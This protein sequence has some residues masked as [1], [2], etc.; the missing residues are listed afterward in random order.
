[1]QNQDRNKELRSQEGNQGE[2]QTQNRGQGQVSQEGSQSE[3]QTPQLPA[4]TLPKGGGAIRGI[5]E[6]FTANPV[7][8]TG[9][10]AVPI[11]VTPSRSG[12]G[13]ELALSYNSGSGNSPFGFGWDLSLPSIT[14]KTDKGLPRYFDGEESDVFI[15]SGA[16]DLVPV[17]TEQ[18]GEWQE[19]E[20]EPQEIDSV[21]YTIKR[22]RP[23][24]EGLFARIER[25]TNQDT[26]ESHWRSITN[27][28]ITTLYGKTTESRIVNPDDPLQIF[29]WLICESYDD[30][31]NAI[32]Y[33]YKPEDRANVGNS[34][35]EERNKQG[36]TSQRYLKRIKYGNSTPRQEGE[37]LS[38]RDDW[39]FEAVFDYGE[40]DDLVPTTAEVDGQ[41]WSVRQ[42]SF[43]NHRAG[44][45][46]RT[47]RLCKRVLMFHHFPDEL[48]VSDYLV[49]STNFN[50]Q[51][52]P[53]ASFIS[54]VEQAGYVRQDDGTYLRKAMPPLELEYSKAI[55]DE[56]VHTLDDKSL[57]N[58]PQG[59]DGANYRWVD[60]DGEGM[61]G[62]L[63]EQG[64]AWHYK[65]NLG[66]GKFGSVT[67]VAKI[68]STANLTQ[69]QQL[70]DLAGDAKLDLAGFAGPTPGFYERT[71]DKSWDSF[72]AFEK[73]PNVNWDDPNLRFVDLT[74]DGLADILIT[75]EDIHTFYPSLGEEGF[76][77][78]QQVYTP[79]N[80]EAGP[81][82]IFAD[83]MQS[84]YLADMS[85][86]GLSDLVK[87]S[88]G[89][90][91]YW[92]SL[93]Y[94]KFGAK[95]TMDN[96]PLFD[97]PDLFEQRRIQLADIDGSGVA[98]IVYFSS[99]GVKLYFNESG[100]SW[101]D[102][103]VLN[104]PK[105]DNLS[106]VAVMDLLGKGTACLVWSSPLPNNQRKPMQYIDLM[107]EQKPYLLLAS[108]NNMG[109]ETRVKYVP[110]TK[111]YR[112]DELKGEPWVTRLPFP[113]HVVERVETHDNISQNRFVS[114]Y[115]YHHGFFDGVEREFRGFG[116]VEQWDTEEYAALTDSEDVPATN[117]DEASHIPPVKTKTW[118]HMGAYIEGHKISQHFVG[119]YYGV[120]DVSDPDYE[121]KF[122]SF[123]GT[124]LPDSILPNTLHSGD[125]TIPWKLTAEEEREASRALK[126]SVLRQEIYA[127]DGTAKAEHPYSVS[128][129]NYTIELLQPEVDN[130]Y[131][132]FFA[133]PRESISYQY[134]RNPD[135]PRISHQ[136]VLEVDR[137]GNALKSAAVGYGRDEAKSRDSFLELSEDNRSI[138]EGKQTTTLLTYS[139]SGFTN[140]IEEA[141]VYQAPLPAEARTYELTGL[142]PAG[143]RFTFAEVLRDISEVSEIPYEAT[144]DGTKQKRLIEHV[145]TLYRKNDLSGALPFGEV[146]SLA[147]PYESY[148]LALTPELINQVYENRVTETM[149]N[150]GGYIH[151][152]GDANWWIPSG[153]IFYSPNPNDSP[154]EELD[155]AQQHFFLPHRL[156]DPF[157]NE[158]T[159]EY[160]SYNL[161]PLKSVD[162]LDNTIETVN[163]YR[164]LQPRLVTDPNG[165]RSEAAFDVLGMVVGTA[166]MGK[167]GENVGDSLVGFETDL[168]DDV[169]S[170][171]LQDPFNDP[172][173]I[174][175][176]ATSRL[177]YDLFAYQRTKD[178]ASPK[179]N[180]VYAL[181]RETHAADL[182]ANEL[183]K[184]QHSF[185]YSDGFGR[186]LQQ[187]I[188]AEPGL[189]D[190]VPTDPRWVGSGWTIYNNKGNPV[191]QYQ[192][193]FSA[194]HEFELETQGVS[195]T[196][197]YDPLERVVATLHPNHTFEKVVFDPWQQTTYDVNDTVL[198]NPKDDVD[199]GDYFKRL[200]DDTYLPTWY[201]ARKDGQLG[202][203]EQ[204][205]AERAALHSETPV[206]AYSD[207]LGRAFLTV[208]HNKFKK[209]VG[210]VEE[211]IEEKHETRVELDIESNQRVVI[212]ARGLEVMQYDYGMLGN[213]I[214]QV[215]MDAGTRW[216]F[217]DVAGKP[218]Y[219]WDS[220]DHVFRSTYD[221]LQRPTGLYVQK[222]AAEEI[223]FER[224]VYGEA[225]PDSQASANGPPLSKLNLRG[226]AFMQLDSAGASTSIGINAATGEEEAFDFKGNPLRGSRQLAKE[227][228]EQVDWS[229]LES[230]FAASELDLAA[231]TSNL[232]AFLEAETFEDSTTFDA[233]SR[234]IIATAPDSSVIRPTFNE[235]NLL[236][237]VE[238]NLRGA[239]EVT[240]FVSNID[241]DAKGQRTLIEY[242]NGARTQYT[243]DPDTF[244]L[245]QLFT[246]RGADFPTDCPDPA[247]RPCGIQNLHYTYDPVGNIT[248]IRDDAQ[249]TVFF[250]NGVAA[251]H[252]KYVYDALYR[253]IGAEGRE[254]I[255][256]VTNPQPNHDDAPRK[257]NPLPSDGQAMRRYVEQYEYDEVGNILK[258]IHSL[259]NLANPGETVWNRRYQYRLDNNQLVSTSQPS[260]ADKPSYSNTPDYTD[261]YT[262]DAHGNM[263]MPHLPVM[264]WDFK[265]QLAATSKQVRNSGGTPETTYYV[266][267]ASGQRV[268]K[269]TERQAPAGENPRRMKERI[270]LGDFEV[271]KEYGGDGETV[272][273]ERETLHVMDD[274]Q[275]IALV[276]TRTQGINPA[277]QQLIRYQFG[278]HLGSAS[279][280]LDDQAQVISYEE[281]T[282]Y[283]STAYQAVRSQTETPKRYR[284]TGMERDEESGLSYHS[285]RYYLPWLGLW[286]TIDPIG[287]EDS[288][289]LYQYT[290]SNPV[291]FFDS[292]G[293]ETKGKKKSPEQLA[294]D[295]FEEYL[296]KRRIKYKK[297]V[298]IEVNVDGEW[299]KGT[300]DFLVELPGK[301]WEPVEF[302]GD[303]ASKW[304][305]NQK[306]YIPALRNGA[307]FRVTGRF[308]RGYKGFGGGKVITLASVAS[309]VKQFQETFH[310]RVIRRTPNFV[311]YMYFNSQRKIVERTRIAQKVKGFAKSRGRSIKKQ[312][313]FASIGA[314]NIIAI[315]TTAGIIFVSEDR[316]DAVIELAKG[317]PYDIALGA[318]FTKLAKGV[319]VASVLT[320]VVG[321]E[322]DSTQHNESL[323]IGRSIDEFIHDN[324][325]G[326]V[327]LHRRC[328]R[329]FG[330]SNW[331]TKVKDSKRYKELNSKLW[332]LVNDKYTFD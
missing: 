252:N 258:M 307:E 260:D 130:Q 89:K 206:V 201:E 276:E 42:D 188:Q 167:E 180:V 81:K 324:F 226:Q 162:P 298:P 331:K 295:Q 310:T 325:P 160:D 96:S 91:C 221:E 28:N 269:V 19:E 305:P 118:F 139:E 183:T 187:K 222:G 155:Y 85:G 327:S 4:I 8:G 306:K 308:Q 125:N 178:S 150:E 104:F 153:Q 321:M 315:G 330:C 193:F 256:Q 199:V 37:D 21:A 50:H 46:V 210:N 273:L 76:D 277:P 230:L 236:E 272:T 294:E 107:S 172:H 31:G 177:V 48:G 237:K 43:S 102:E 54:S 286:T 263:Q 57:E 247:N 88:N 52:N 127:L 255:G 275:R 75:E 22:Y 192:P 98:D 278:N 62:I 189:V 138:Y 97:F 326:V 141:N 117:I 136:L 32:V 66:E 185:S 159:L 119:E 123:E 3:S 245:T 297:K 284:Y 181:V 49:S 147:L 282:P 11:A 287:V 95:V 198:L 290:Q 29:S 6:K 39:L 30:Q 60:L 211:T 86:D 280:E 114:R 246:T 105:I 303:D 40:H 164:V 170:A 191:K 129:Q 1:M 41:A 248:N 35:L 174:L 79:S 44:F 186:D 215:S 59:L 33:E 243:Y 288:L 132:V 291:V 182:G 304:T 109:A 254:H 169:I 227:Y 231:I 212:D 93:G 220:R 241:Y 313:G 126:G 218:L 99:S 23:R 299:I 7:T 137:F 121:A 270:Y 128:E 301:R 120:P 65:P 250:D 140:A 148:Q 154:T 14:R 163:D 296:K 317:V 134:E 25:W 225:H 195:S 320:I 204:V 318:V 165:N 274:A 82:L 253:L 322:S 34:L 13:P 100:N 74:G 266:Y 111:F 203:K 200:P 53:I 249:Q 242:G 232:A 15:L 314:L 285:A 228:K 194:T 240:T 319:G 156:R 64:S 92:P 131:A 116:M 56:T 94:G 205:A 142:S 224:T 271:Y 115:A 12:F 10:L 133:H 281:Y 51:E 9:S 265:D 77:K 149:L 264:N 87:I 45:E 239:N 16:E 179:P 176:N 214:R 83:G 257:N 106:S 309:A 144:P 166:V 213:G 171:H 157:G 216:T 219:S 293:T 207:T 262:H 135:D 2:T 158:G 122:Q 233:L 197:F 36:A 267:D 234:P 323:A 24:I 238:V 72:V 259:G 184:I 329:V 300:P 168:A 71:E 90:V 69:R 73:L 17:L 152:E 47:Y 161:L 235:A 316:L 55:I 283:G 268:R 151:S 68:P 5:G 196:L 332:R 84:V 217:T 80:E 108:R 190:G 63:T 27:D 279:L 223:L 112:E 18:N 143:K 175:G 292:S 146:E 38:T 312:G 101:S 209:K 311:E 251:P 202:T 302:K 20:V 229:S 328:M 145:R 289:N 70:I 61:F 58:L 67:Q 78:A 244:R 208:A 124:L 261:K 110:S 173:E 103:R 113:V 26:G